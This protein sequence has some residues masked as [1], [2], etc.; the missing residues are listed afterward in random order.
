[1]LQSLALAALSALLL[2][3]GWLFPPLS[4]LAFFG[5]WPL[6]ESERRSNAQAVK[7][8]NLRWLGLAAFF[9]F[10]YGLFPWLALSGT[11][12]SYLLSAAL[13]TLALTLFHF[14]KSYHG[15][16]RGYISLPFLWLSAE[17]MPILLNWDVF[18]SKPLGSLFWLWADAWLNLQALG[19]LG[20]S[21]LVLLANLLLF[22]GLR[23]L[24]SQKQWPKFALRAILLIGLLIG[25]TYLLA[26]YLPSGDV[27]RLP[28]QEGPGET[29]LDEGA[30]YLS[31][32][33]RFLARLSLF[34]AFFLSI[35]A[36]V[37]AYLKDRQI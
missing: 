11:V 15:A 20:V 25:L 28:Y 27:S 9:A 36:I 31:R 35:F 21:L 29:G 16:Q 33:D 14:V 18:E 5:L 7:H 6:L 3:L 26:H 10:V 34:L 17:A 24:L 23:E 19:F 37:R 2:G 22:L 12:I 32:L 8:P 13:L 1:M 4:T 30:W